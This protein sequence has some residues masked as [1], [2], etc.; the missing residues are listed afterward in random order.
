LQGIVR[1]VLA[2]ASRFIVLASEFREPLRSIVNPERIVVVPNGIAWD[3]AERVRARPEQER[4]YR[5]LFLSTLT[6]DKGALLL[7]EAAAQ[8]L[9]QRRDVEFVLAG[10]WGRVR[11]EQR[12]TELMGKH[13]LHEFVRLP[14]QVDGHDKTRLYESADL[15]VFPGIQQEG[16][17]LVVLE[18]MAAG[19]PVVFSDRGCLAATVREGEAGVSF[20]LGDARELAERLLWLVARPELMQQLGA[21]ARRRYEVHY[22]EQRF[23]SN[24]RRVFLEAA[25]ED[26]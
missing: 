22:S 13:G 6:E 4:R 9:S 7:L 20:R 8:V 10:P 5:I 25:R 12:A 19:L 26:A 18:A 1:A 24:M 15:F 2:P 3:G 14:G 23:I 21:N 16:Q 17:P 11:D